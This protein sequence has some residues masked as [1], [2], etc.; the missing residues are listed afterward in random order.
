MIHGYG[1]DAKSL[2]R[3]VKERIRVLTQIAKQLLVKIVK[4]SHFG[5]A[6][7]PSECDMRISLFSF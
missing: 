6:Y 7:S 4:L 2:R 3:I 5:A 1:M